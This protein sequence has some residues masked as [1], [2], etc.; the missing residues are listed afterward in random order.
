MKTTWSFYKLDTGRFTGKRLTG[1]SLA[2]VPV[3]CGAVE[4]EF[5]HRTQRVDIATGAVIAFERPAAE[6]EAEQKK[7]RDREARHRIVKLEASQ[8]RAMRELLIDPNNAQAR[9]RLTNI[10]TEIA[11]LRPDLL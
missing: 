5:D 10:E 6:I 4:G 9:Q 7:R 1:P 2:G 8:Q 3:D 11:G